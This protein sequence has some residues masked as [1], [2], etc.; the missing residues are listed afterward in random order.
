MGANSAAASKPISLGSIWNN[1]DVS[2]SAY[3]N[4]VEKIFTVYPGGNP[5]DIKLEFDG[6]TVEN[7][8]AKVILELDILVGDTIDQII[9]E[10]FN[11]AFENLNGIIQ[12]LHILAKLFN[13]TLDHCVEQA[14]NQIKD[15]KGITLENGTFIKESDP[16]YKEIV[17]QNN[18]KEN[19]QKEVKENQNNSIKKHKKLKKK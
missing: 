17:E 7:G 3:Q 13:T 15:R 19:T 5:A 14:Y 16:R 12:Y 18:S 4:N 1:V 9:K 10:N 11:Q 6:K 8:V 2:L